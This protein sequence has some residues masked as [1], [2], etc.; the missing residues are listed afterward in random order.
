MGRPC[1]DVLE[2]QR[3]RLFD[4]FAN[5]L[6]SLADRRPPDFIIGERDAPYLLRWWLI[7]RNRYFNLYL[8]R[9]CQSDDDR[10][11]HDHPWVNMSIL[12]RGRYIEHTSDGQAIERN[13]GAV[14]MRPATAAHRIELIHGRDGLLGAWS[15]FITGP[16]TRS[17]GFL[18][19]QGWRHWKDFTSYRALGEDGRGRIGR[20]CE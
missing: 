17:W 19:P 15:L 4:Y 6:I 5:C 11:L 2:W 3:M 9:F 1:R 16:V 8:H 7:P 18:C 20:G 12:L 10:A 14:V 13:A